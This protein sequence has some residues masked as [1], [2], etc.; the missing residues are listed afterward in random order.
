MTACLGCRSELSMDGHRLPEIYRVQPLLRHQRPASNPRGVP[1]HDGSHRQ[2]AAPAGHLPG[3]DGARDP[4]GFRR[5]RAGYAALGLPQP[6]RSARQP[7]GHQHPQRWLVLLA[8][9]DEAPISVPRAGDIVCE[10]TSVKPAVPTWFALR[11]DR[12]LFAFAGLWRPWTGTRGTKADPAEGEHHLF[13][14]LTCAPNAVV[15][16]VHPKA[17]PVILTTPAECEAWMT[18]PIPEAVEL[19][20]P[21]PDGPL[22]IVAHGHKQDPPLSL[23]QPVAGAQASLL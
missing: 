5:A 17:M 6:A 8:S 19:Q 22:E 14:F 9:L 11:T 16:P 12:P 4:S 1:G 2:S 10:Y 20:R 15:E 21:L 18:A 13:A 23:A 3:P 7:A